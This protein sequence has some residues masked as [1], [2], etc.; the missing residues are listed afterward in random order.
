VDGVV[1][2]EV[3]GRCTVTHMQDGSKVGYTRTLIALHLH[4]NLDLNPRM[5]V[6]ITRVF[7]LLPSSQ[8][9]RFVTSAGLFL[10]MPSI[11]SNTSG[12]NFL[13]TSTALTV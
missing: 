11:S 8:P 10:K 13:Y 2:G 1:D 6:A 5:I 3:V 4:S 9:N 12:V 7:M